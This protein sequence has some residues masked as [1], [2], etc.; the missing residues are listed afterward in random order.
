MHHRA[1]RRDPDVEEEVEADAHGADHL[2]RR[3]RLKLEQR[4]GHAGWQSWS[5]V[6]LGAR[7]AVVEVPY[8]ASA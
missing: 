4:R 1:G 6:L 3:V 5:F 2:R 7:A 8:F